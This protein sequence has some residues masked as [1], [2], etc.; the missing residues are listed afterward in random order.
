MVSTAW[1]ISFKNCHRGGLKTYYG[2]KFNF[3]LELCLIVWVSGFSFFYF[4]TFFYSLALV[5]AVLRFIQLKPKVLNPWLN[6]SGLV[7]LCL[8]SFGMTLL[9]NF[10]VLH[11]A[12]FTFVSHFSWMII[13]ATEGQSLCGPYHSARIFQNIT[14]SSSNM[15]SFSSSQPVWSLGLVCLTLHYTLEDAHHMCWKYSRAAGKNN[16]KNRCTFSTE[17]FK[18]LYTSFH[19]KLYPN[20]PFYKTNRITTFLLL[21]TEH[22][23]R[24]KACLSD[25]QAQVENPGFL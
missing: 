1:K 11:L 5:V 14:N 16:Y 9:G 3:A 24:M 4:N 12:F 8:S 25:E 20:V 23:F 19:H 6:I 10:Q 15:R 21:N 13:T 18:V 17:D 7:A 2:E 22:P